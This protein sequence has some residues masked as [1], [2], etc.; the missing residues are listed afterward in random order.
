[1]NRVNV[2]GYDADL[3]DATPGDLWPPGGSYA[4][5]SAEA[6]TTVDSTS[7]D[8]DG[9][10]AGTGARTVRVH[11]LDD[12]F[13][14]IVEDV[15]MNGTTAVTCT[16]TF[17]RVNFVEVLTAGSGG[18]NAGVITVLHGATVLSH[19]VIGENRSRC[20]IYTAPLV[21]KN[22]EIRNIHLAKQ[23]AVVGTVTATL[24]TRKNGGA[25]QVRWSSVIG[26]V[27]PVSI[28]KP[29]PVPIALE[30]GEDVRLYVDSSA[31]NMV[32]NG[33]FDVVE[34]SAPLN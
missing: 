30:A 15:T 25:W 20:A 31:D 23:D 18:G 1:M 8:D 28:D 12:T 24:Y 16:N 11:G 29:L 2:L 34:Q 14:P 33:G 19:M 6:T 27:G 4:W 3:D 10:P 32:V 9:D 22:A 13:R 21:P 7:T 5:P 17:Y 26:S